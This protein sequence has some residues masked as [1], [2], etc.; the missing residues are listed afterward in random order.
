MEV[1][2]WWSEHVRKCS[3]LQ[4]AYKDHATSKEAGN[5]VAGSLKWCFTSIINGHRI[6]PNNDRKGVLLC[7]R[8]HSF[9]GG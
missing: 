3:S 5:H 4:H 2:A 9:A 1:G 6:E 7:S 8:V